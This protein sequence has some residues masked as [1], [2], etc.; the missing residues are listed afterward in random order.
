MKHKAYNVCFA[1]GMKERYTLFYH[2]VWAL[3]QDHAED[4]AYALLNQLKIK[5]KRAKDYLIK[6]VHE[7]CI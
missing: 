5:N 7:V 3:N 6:F 1:R 4:K 2:T